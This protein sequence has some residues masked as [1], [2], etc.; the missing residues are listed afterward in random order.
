[1]RDIEIKDVNAKEA[2]VRLGLDVIMLLEDAA[3]M[4]GKYYQALFPSCLVY[5]VP[6]NESR[7]RRYQALGT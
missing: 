6:H 3:L 7:H 2:S 5:T 4:L 1:M